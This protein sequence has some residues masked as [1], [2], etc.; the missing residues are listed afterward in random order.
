MA[1]LYFMHALL[2]RTVPDLKCQDIGIEKVGLGRRAH[3]LD[4]DVRPSPRM[5]STL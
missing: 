3:L 1:C 5:H 2:E 4:C